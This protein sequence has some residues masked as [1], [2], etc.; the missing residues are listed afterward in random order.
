MRV[1]GDIPAAAPSKMASV[2]GVLARLAN[3]V[4]RWKDGP[5]SDV[6]VGRRRRRSRTQHAVDDNDDTDEEEDKSRDM[7]MGW[8]EV[9]AEVEERPVDRWVALMFMGLLLSV[10]FNGFL[11]FNGPVNGC[12]GIYKDAGRVEGGEKFSFMDGEGRN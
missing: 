8:R 2:R 1:H 12:G 5:V 11:V 7:G 3:L 9:E 6:E 10:L 4:G